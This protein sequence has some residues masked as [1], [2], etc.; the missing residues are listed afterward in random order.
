MRLSGSIRVDAIVVALANL[1]PL[2]A[3]NRSN[4]YAIQKAL[5]ER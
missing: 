1:D 2:P 4:C 5:D 3:G